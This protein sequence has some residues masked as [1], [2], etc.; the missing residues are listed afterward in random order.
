[1]APSNNESN[2]RGIRPFWQNHTVDPPIPWED[3]SD[4]FHLAIIAKENIDIEN[5]INPSEKHHLQP[6]SL[7]NPLNG[8]MENQKKSRIDRNIQKQRRYDEEET[9]SIKTETKKFNGKRL[10]EADKKLRSVLYLALGNEEKRIFGQKVTRVKILQIS[11]KEFLDYLA[12]AFVRKTNITF[13]RHKLLNRK[14]RDRESL[15]QF[16]GALAE[17]AEKCDIA[18]GEEEWIR[19]ILKNNMKTYDTQRKILT[20][21]LPPR[22]ALNVALID[23]KGILNHLKLT[24]KFKSNG[25][26]VHKPHSHFIVKREPTLNIEKSNTCVKCGGTFSKGHLA[27]CSAK[28]STCTSCKNKGHFTRLCKSRRR[29]VRIVNNQMVDNTDFNP[30]DLPDVITNHVI[31]ECCGVINAWSESGQSENDNFSVLNI[32]TI[33]DND[34]K[35]LKKLL[36]FGLG[37]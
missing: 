14:Q 21:T 28:D 6:P 17:M 2:V 18:A 24:I 5:L 23:K 15:E 7:E 3:W 36:N 32:T 13:E 29:N 9:A 10:E 35:E 30:S 37:K 12:T 16:W 19:D 20:K 1:M 11:F 4:L 26:S 25:S 34:G 33:F 22:E 31:R 8:E 27:V